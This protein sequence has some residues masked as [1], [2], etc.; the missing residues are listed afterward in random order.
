MFEVQ[1]TSAFASAFRI[2]GAAGRQH[3]VHSLGHRIGERVCRDPEWHVLS[4]HGRAVVA[5]ACDPEASPDS[6]AVVLDVPPSEA[7]SVVDDLLEAGLIRT[8]GLGDRSRL[9]VDERRAESVEITPGRS[10]ADLLAVFLGPS[11]RVT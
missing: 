1:D 8:A 5:I 7:V 4:V 6:L 3:R 2:R 11:D 9:R 10:V